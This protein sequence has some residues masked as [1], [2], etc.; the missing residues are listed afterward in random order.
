MM[1]SSVIIA[2]FVFVRSIINLQTSDYRLMYIEASI[3]PSLS[4]SLICTKIRLI[5]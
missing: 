2:A 5:L 4:P 3:C 1:I